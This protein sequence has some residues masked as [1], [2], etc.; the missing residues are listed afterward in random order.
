M[1]TIYCLCLFD[2]LGLSLLKRNFRVVWML[3]CYSPSGENYSHFQFGPFEEWNWRPK[4]WQI[5]YALV[6]WEIITSQR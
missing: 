2:I 6:A 5:F 1:M 3:L 4:A